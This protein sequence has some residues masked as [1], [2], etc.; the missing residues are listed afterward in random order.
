MIASKGPM[1]IPVMQEILDR[2]VSGTY[3]QGSALPSERELSEEFDISR[4]V[5]RESVKVLTEKGLVTTWRGRGTIVEPASRW[6]TFDPDLLAA[7]LRYPGGEAV[8]R[9]LLILR[10]GIEPVVASM[11]AVHATTDQRRALEQRFAELERCQHDAAEYVVADGDFHDEIV[12]IAGVAIAADLFA[13]MAEP[14]TLSRRGTALIPGG[15]QAA[16]AQHRRVYECIQAGDGPGASAAM[17][18][19]IES[20]E[21]RLEQLRWSEHRLVPR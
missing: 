5:L 15:L 7:R 10:R 9:E 16:H 3:P 19:H 6:R 12:R 8:I 17:I 14:F 1:W 13:L 4:T 11:A 18:E 20:A 2:I 21:S